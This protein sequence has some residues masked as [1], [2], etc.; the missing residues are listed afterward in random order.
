[1]ALFGK[2]RSFQDSFYY[3]NAAQ[4]YYILIRNVSIQLRLFLE[5]SVVKMLINVL[6]VSF[7]FS[8]GAY[9]WRNQEIEQFWNEIFYFVVFR[10]IK[11]ILRRPETAHEL[12][13][14]RSLI[15][16]SSGPY[17]RNKNRVFWHSLTK[18]K[19]SK[20]WSDHCQVINRSTIDL[21]CT[22]LNKNWERNGQKTWLLCQCSSRRNS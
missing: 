7:R 22:E 20:I 16:S 1:M 2:V 11:S 13:V 3:S 4:S 9:N 5:I 21:H 17:N 18:P 6:F 14:N 8:F 15:T 12:Q 10:S 19:K